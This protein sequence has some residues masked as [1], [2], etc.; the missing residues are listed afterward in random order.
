MTRGAAVKVIFLLVALLVAA[1]A[2][3]VHAQVR[4]EIGIHLPAPPA[5]VVIPGTPVYSAPR[6]PANVFFYA[7]E[8]WISPTADGMSGRHGTVH[9]RSSNLPT[10]R[11]PF[12]R[13][14]SAT[15][16]CPRRS[17]ASGVV[18]G[19]RSGSHTTD[20]NGAKKRMSVTGVNASSPG[21]GARAKAALPDSPSKGGASVGPPG[22][23]LPD[24]ATIPMRDPCSR[25][26]K[27]RPGDAL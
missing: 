19:R 8:Y 11:H 7:H 21:I 14:P 16:R 22:S 24:L 5:L 6:A 27:N 20:G 3:P 9:G 15:T 17:G 12:F 26:E 13:S 18:M 25:G 23:Q 4:V 2:V 10:S 1:V